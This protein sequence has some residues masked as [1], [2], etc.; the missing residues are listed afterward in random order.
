MGIMVEMGIKQEVRAMRASRFLRAAK[1][2]FFS[3]EKL[4]LPEV[5]ATKSHFLQPRGMQEVL[6]SL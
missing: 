1:K 6:E 5:W 3:Q 4:A 2:G